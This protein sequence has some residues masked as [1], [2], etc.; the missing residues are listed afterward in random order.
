MAK[1]LCEV[2]SCRSFRAFLVLMVPLLSLTPM[3]AVCLQYACNRNEATEILFIGV[4]SVQ[5]SAQLDIA[6]LRM[7][8]P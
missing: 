7:N 6:L 8:T 3:S 2:K 5:L 4:F 1:A